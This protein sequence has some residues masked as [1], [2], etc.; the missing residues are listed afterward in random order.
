MSLFLIA[1]TILELDSVSK[2]Y[3]TQVVSKEIS[4]RIEPGSI[5]GLLGPNGAGKTTLLRMMA[6]ITKPDAGHIRFLGE[7]LVDIHAHQMGYMP[8]ERGLYKRMSVV[9]QL[10]FFAEIRGLSRAEAQGEIRHWMQ[11]LHMTDWINSSSTQG[12]KN[13]VKQSKKLEELSKG[14]AQKLQFLCTIIH[15]PKLLILDEPFSGFDPVNADLIRDIILDLKQQGTAVV[16]STH[17]MDNI[18]S[19]CDDITLINQGAPLFQGKTM[20]VRRSQFAGHYDL[21]IAQDQ[22]LV[23]SPQR[24][25]SHERFV[26]TFKSPEGNWIHRFQCDEQ[27]ASQTLLELGAKAGRVVH[28]S[29]YIPSIHDIFVQSVQS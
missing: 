17:R 27:F 11:R 16:F 1:M 10:L 18:E 4:M 26:K 22:E 8:E 19:L 5:H 6:T 12:V 24:W 20:E 13:R 7:P 23:E 9:D 21:A 15:K 29:E 25:L 2:S 3:A 14:M 28:F